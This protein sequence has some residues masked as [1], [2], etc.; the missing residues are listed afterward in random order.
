MEIDFIFPGEPVPYTM[1][2]QNN[3]WADAP[4]K[5]LKYKHA[6]ARALK[7]AFSQFQIPE[8][9]PKK[10]PEHKAW[11][12]EQKHTFYGLGVDVWLARD[13]GDHDNFRK[14]AQDSLQVA[15]LIWNDKKVIH[16]LSAWRL[17]D[18]ENPR[19]RLRLIKLNPEEIPGLAVKDEKRKKKAREND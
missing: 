2:T 13:I 3:K 16:T 15:G 17:I 12:K 19:L 10:T 1:M 6:L 7:E 8:E 5:Y 11:K 9:P 18:E 4:Q 14:G